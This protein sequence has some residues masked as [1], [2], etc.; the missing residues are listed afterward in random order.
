[1]LA[2]YNQMMEDLNTV[3]LTAIQAEHTSFPEKMQYVVETLVHHYLSDTRR[4]RV[5]VL[6]WSVPAQR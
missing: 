5:G 2:L 1:M 3:L 6:K 4:A